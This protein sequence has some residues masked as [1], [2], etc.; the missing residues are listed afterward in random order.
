[1]WKRTDYG[2]TYRRTDGQMDMCKEVVS[3]EYQNNKYRVK[4]KD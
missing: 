3:Q 4:I 1:M 2:Q